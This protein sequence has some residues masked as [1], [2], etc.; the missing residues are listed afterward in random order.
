MTSRPPDPTGWERP[1]SR[2]MRADGQPASLDD[3]AGAG[4]YEGLARALKELTPP[5]VTQT[6]T[7]SGLRG[8]GGA[9]F[10]T[11]RKWS[12]MPLGPDAPHPK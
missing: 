3:Y 2:A 10:S 1:L 7:D 6:V 9:G 4:G 8:R 11:G 5:E 12:T